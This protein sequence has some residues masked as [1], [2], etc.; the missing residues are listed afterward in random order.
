MSFTIGTATFTNGSTAVTAVSLTSGRLSY[1]ASG[2]RMV[3]SSNPVIAEVEAIAAPSNTQITLAEPWGF[4][5]GTY[6]FLA[7]MTAEGIRDAAQSIRSIIDSVGSVSTTAVSNT[8]AK[9]DSDGRLE[10]TAGASG[11]DVLTFGNV[12]TSP[13]DTTAGRVLQTGDGGLMGDARGAPADLN[14]IKVP[15]AH[16][17]TTVTVT[18]LPNDFPDGTHTFDV[19]TFGFFGSG[20]NSRLTQYL[21]ITN[22]INSRRTWVRTKHDST[23]ASWVELLH[24]GNLNVNEFGVNAIDD[25]VAPG[26]PTSATTAEFE[27]TVPFYA[28]P[29]SIIVTGTFSIVDRWNGQVLFSGVTPLLGGRSSWNTVILVVTGLS[30]FTKDQSL[31]LE[32]DTA[33]SKIKVNP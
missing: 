11:N 1:F 28:Q 22:G 33:T 21:T 12:T 27:L 23:W 13:T 26:C 3:V 7:N 24:S 8:T 20:S 9:R 32:A 17:T 2:T 29:S 6:S 31:R 18:N 16:G 25:F 10:A 15:Y 5:T 4:A 30:G 19:H 14:D